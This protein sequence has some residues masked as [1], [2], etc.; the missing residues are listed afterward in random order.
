MMRRGLFLDSGGLRLVGLVLTAI[1]GA[2]VLIDLY[3]RGGAFPVVFILA[4]L[5]VLL[6]VYLAFLREGPP[7]ERTLRAVDKLTSGPPRQ[8]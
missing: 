6:A 4:T 2:L 7:R 8:N 1:S 3:A 5:A